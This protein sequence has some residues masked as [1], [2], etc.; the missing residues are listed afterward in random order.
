MLADALYGPTGRPQPDA[1][2]AAAVGA[3]AAL[4]TAA[5]TVN[6]RTAARGPGGPWANPT[7]ALVVLLGLAALLINFSVRVEV[8]G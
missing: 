4:P 3:G 5:G 8:R 1:T 7:L 6:A 2:H